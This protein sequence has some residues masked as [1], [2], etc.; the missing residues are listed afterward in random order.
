VT[1]SGERRPTGRPARA[2][3]PT[4]R[5]KVPQRT[6]VACRAVRAKRDLVRVVRTIDGAVLVDATGKKT[7][8]G[9]YLCRQRSCWEAGLRRG[10][11]ERALKQA[12]PAESRAALEAYAATLPEQLAAPD[13]LME[14]EA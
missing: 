9:A 2:S 5:R 11:L 4:S 7:G 3:S 13:S 1:T 6:C 12:V 8:R 10:V 14:R